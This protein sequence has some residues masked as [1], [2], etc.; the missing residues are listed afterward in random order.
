MKSTLRVA[1]LILAVISSM[2]IARPEASRAGGPPLV[3]AFDITVSLEWEPGR[4]DVSGASLPSALAA[5]GCPAEA[6]ATYLDDLS[7][8]LTDA[9]RFLY[10][11]SRG[12]F[13]LGTVTIDTEGARWGQADIRILAE[14]SYRPTADVGGIVA[15]PTSNSSAATGVSVTFYPGAVTL[16]RGWD[17][18]GGRCG[19]WSQP[20]AWRTIGHEWGHYALYLWDEYYE[21][22]TLR[23][24]YC[25]TTGFTRLDRR[26][27]DRAPAAVDSGRS[28]VMAY[29]YTTDRL[30][31]SGV[32]ASCSETPQMRVNG[33]SDW[34]TIQRFYPGVG[35]PTDTPTSP[36]PAPTIVVASAAPTE[37]TTA[38]VKAEGF[39]TADGAAR[40]YLVRGAGGGQPTRIIGQGELLQGEQATLLGA[41]PS[42]SDRAHV[43]FEDWASGARYVFPA[44]PATVAAL[45]TAPDGSVTSLGLAATTWRPALRITPVVSQI[46]PTTSELT[47][48]QLRIE[49]CARYTKQI[50][51]VFCPAGGL[52]NNQQTLNVGVGGVFT[53]SITLP[54]EI[55]SR[56]SAAHGYIYMRS[57]DTNEELIST[58]Q[59]GGGAGSGH[60]GAHPPLLDAQ[61]LVETPAGKDPPTG[62]DMRVLTSTALV[63][64]TPALPPGIRSIVGNPVDIQPVLADQQGG[65]SWGSLV[66]DPPLAVKLSYSQDLID[67]LGID[68][69]SLV[70]LRVGQQGAWEAVPPA[71]RSADLDWVS[72]AARALDGNGAIY[73]LGYAD[74]RVDL[75]LVVR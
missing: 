72:G 75:P 19:A 14:S 41:R 5:S 4:Q 67:R 23:E 58:Y 39:P 15:T 28:S 53:A 35:A 42:L 22:F 64:Q 61:V 38:R 36:A 26:L 2:L 73:A 48:L 25:T 31:E 46:S 1:P 71:G 16:G 33:V 37:Y 12:R 30:W 45:P 13:A 34:E 17:G 50:Q 27:G 32:P 18:R 8:G 10:A 69:R 3:Q 24:E 56:Q 44:N 59:I 74:L 21:Q 6:Q 29:H 60:I 62:Q 9:S 43:A 11:Y 68:E 49:D 52:C 7:A 20:E 66:S 40:A 65:R 55:A 47:G 51:L 70:L 57:I 54:D 63:C